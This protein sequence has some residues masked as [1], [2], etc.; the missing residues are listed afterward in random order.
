[1]SRIR[2]VEPLL[3]IVAAV[4]AA[5]LQFVIFRVRSFEVLAP[6]SY[7]R[8][9]R[10]IWGSQAYR[11]WWAS[12]DHWQGAAAFFLIATFAIFIILLQNAVLT[13]IVSAASVLFAFAEPGIDWLNAD[14]HYGWLPVERVFRASYLSLALRGLSLSALIIGFGE[15][16]TLLF[17][18]VA[19]V[20]LVFVLV[21][22]IVPYRML[23]THLNS[24]R[25]IQI[26]A[27]VRES[28]KFRKSRGIRRR[29]IARFY[30]AEIQRVREARI[31]PM[32][33]PK[34]QLSTFAVAVLLPVVLTIVQVAL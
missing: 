10:D 34:W 17:L 12:Y 2:R 20:W 14:G 21:Y 22:H 7:S 33:L 29:E 16:S 5:L 3:L 28:R 31:N 6:Y 8:A 18:F 4:L 30:A 25:G 24:V 27:L 23:F 13:A 11:S 1:M 32:H 15:R 19:V 26:D 9:E